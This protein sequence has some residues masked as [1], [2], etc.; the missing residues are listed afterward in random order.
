MGGTAIKTEENSV[1]CR[2][3]SWTGVGAVEAYRVL[4]REVCIAIVS[5]GPKRHVYLQP[6]RKLTAGRFFSFLNCAFLSAV[7]IQTAPRPAAVMKP[8][9][10]MLPEAG[11]DM[12]ELLERE[13]EERE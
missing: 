1:G 10:L 7:G 6:W 5:V 11:A 3:P 2:C 4:E 9:A 13:R 8:S 12:V